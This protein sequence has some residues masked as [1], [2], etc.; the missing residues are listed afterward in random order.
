MVE[1][2]PKPSPSATTLTELEDEPEV[3]PAHDVLAL[4][5]LWSAREPHRVG[6]VALFPPEHPQWLL[7]RGLTDEDLRLQG[8]EQSGL[9]VPFFRQRPPGALDRGEPTRDGSFLL[10]EGI[11]RRQL[12]IHPRHD[13]LVVMNIG[14][15][16]LLVN[17][18][19]VQ[20]ALVRP[21]STLFL[22]NQLLLYCTIRPL[23]MPPLRA[24]PKERAS[25]FGKPDQ[26]GMVGESPAMWKLRE[27]LAAFA[28][29][30]FHVLITGESGSGKE[31]AAQALHRMSGRAAQRMISDNIAT[32]PASLAAALLFGNR[33]NF[34]NPGMEERA[35]LIGAAHQS[36]LFLDEIGDMPEE[37]QPMFLRVTERG[38]EYF[39]LGE[40]HR[41]L[42]SDFRLVGATNRPQRLR[43]E[44]KRR[45]QREIHL[46]SLNERREDIPLLI[47]SILKLQAQ[48]DDTG[49][50]RFMR[51][52]QPQIHPLLIE[53][54]VRHH[55]S[56]NV[57]EV[58]FLLGQAMAE[59]PHDVISRCEPGP[60]YGS[61]P[62][63]ASG[64]S[65]S[66]GKRE[67]GRSIP[68]S[69]PTRERAEQVLLEQ[70]GDVTRSA[71]ILNIS[72][73]Q[74]NRLIQREG[75]FVPKMRRPRRQSS[76]NEPR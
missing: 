58:G 26:D 55:Y 30:N 7:G 76:D 15:C 35:G 46:T 49:I 31:L 69:L 40:E 1:E 61:A 17:Q 51:D 10:G 57:S 13:G 11:S 47:D 72:R 12:E 66:S 64:A 43:H 67:S 25:S 42:R 18:V 29:T 36:T 3:Q 14:R 2:Q 9:P 54:L 71:A 28:R 52:G 53:Q 32:I 22:R 38:G 20:D 39:R 4:V 63:V 8:Q 41:P 56:T 16:P 70:G 65:A 59:S 73:D 75:L 45:F 21:G 68:R 37:V 23:V 6:E 19:P 5:I 50:T 44:L 60:R 24:Y 62:E 74:L 33:R 34:P 48:R 27:S